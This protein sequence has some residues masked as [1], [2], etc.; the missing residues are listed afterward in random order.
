VR[1]VQTGTRIGIDPSSAGNELEKFRV[2]I[3]GVID[4]INKMRLAPRVLKRIQAH[5]HSVF[6]F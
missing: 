4:T 2:A 1:L 3:P 6:S 5:L